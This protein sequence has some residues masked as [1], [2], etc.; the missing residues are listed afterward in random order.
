LLEPHVRVDRV[1]RRNEAELLLDLL[2][3]GHVRPGALRVKLFALCRLA[4]TLAL[5]SISQS[6]EVCEG[7]QMAHLFCEHLNVRRIFVPHVTL[8]VVQ[9]QESL[10]VFV[11]L[12]VVL[13]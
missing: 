6:A 10:H 9:V 1:E 7:G 3:V 8:F 12:F 11:V 4:Q 5:S 13:M 2:F